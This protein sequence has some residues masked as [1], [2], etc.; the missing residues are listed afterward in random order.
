MVYLR[1]PAVCPHS[2]ELFMGKYASKKVQ[3]RSREH[4]GAKSFSPLRG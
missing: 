4:G 3:G 2:G 1:F